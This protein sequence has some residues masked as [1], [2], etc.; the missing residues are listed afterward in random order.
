MADGLRIVAPGVA[1]TLQDGGRR[2]FLRFGISGSGR[3]IPISWRWPTP[4]WAIRRHGGGRDGDARPDP[5][6][7]GGGMPRRLAGASFAMDLNG[8]TLDPF[9]AHDLRRGDR[10]TLGAPRQGLRAGSRWPGASP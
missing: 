7:R 6:L 2:G 4:W 8:R 5:G 10:L 9:T 1:T 3:W